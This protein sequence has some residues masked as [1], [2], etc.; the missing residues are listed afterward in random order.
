MI[1]MMILMGARCFTDPKSMVIARRYHVCTISMP[2]PTHVPMPIWS[3][4]KRVL[5]G[6]IVVNPSDLKHVVELLGCSDGLG[7]VIWARMHR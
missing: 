6:K 3:V 4:E 2:L 1:S 5:F 7:V